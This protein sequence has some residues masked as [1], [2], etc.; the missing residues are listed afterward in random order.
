MLSEVAIGTETMLGA[1]KAEKKVAI[2]K[3]MIE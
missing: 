2:D 3:V 1:K